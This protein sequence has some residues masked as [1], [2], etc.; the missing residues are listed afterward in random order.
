MVKFLAPLLWMLLGPYFSG[1]KQCQI[2]NESNRV[3]T[4]KFG[5]LLCVRVVIEDLFE[6]TKTTQE[7]LKK[8][9]VFATLTPSLTLTQFHSTPTSIPI[10][11]SSAQK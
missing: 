11:Q 3:S 2:Q 5:V 1:G 6:N 10:N 7:Q 8:S 4:I 9:G